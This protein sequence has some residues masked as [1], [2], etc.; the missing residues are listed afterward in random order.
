VEHEWP[1]NVRE[2]RNVIERLLVFSDRDAI[3]AK[4]VRGALN[5]DRP[6][7]SPE[8]P[9][10]LREARTRFEREFIVSSLVAYDWKIQDTADSLGINRSHLWK[11]MKQLGIDVERKS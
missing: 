11:K 3:G 6:V 10:D 9:A 7:I 8:P 1:G 2:L 5:A 4:D